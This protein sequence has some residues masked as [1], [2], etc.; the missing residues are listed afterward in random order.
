[1]F[2]STEE[3]VTMWVGP[4]HLAGEYQAEEDGNGELAVAEEDDVEEVWV[5][6]V[7]Q[8]KPGTWSKM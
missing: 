4:A 5:G 2:N 6:G 7:L 1:M 3:L 8:E